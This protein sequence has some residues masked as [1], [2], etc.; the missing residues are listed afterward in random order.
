MITRDTVRHVAKL[1]RL[2]LSEQEETQLT[3]QLGAI[4]GYVEQLSEV[5]TAGVEPTAHALPLV[6][7][8]RPD[9]PRPSLSQAEVLQN[10]PA[11]EQGMFRVPRILSE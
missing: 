9:E 7:V 10:A 2:E 5:D 1:A 4:L 11:S 3:E 6:N 8:L